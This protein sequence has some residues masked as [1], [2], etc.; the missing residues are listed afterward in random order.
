MPIQQLVFALFLQALIA[1][2]S[3]SIINPTKILQIRAK[4]GIE[5]IYT[6]LRAS[7][8][9]YKKA[10]P[11]LSCQTLTSPEGVDYEACYVTFTNYPTNSNWRTTIFPSHG[12][13]PHP[14]D[15]MTWTYDTNATGAYF[16]LS[17]GNPKSSTL[18][19]FD[20]IKDTLGV[21]Q[22]VTANNCGVTNDIKAAEAHNLAVT[23]WV[24]KF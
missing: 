16:C 23:Y 19:A 3:I 21:G 8:L 1:A 20:S 4:Y 11:A 2:G 13:L 10:N 17:G 14:V 15:G 12:F 9:S 24:E 18:S 5:T 7:W 6:D 22:L